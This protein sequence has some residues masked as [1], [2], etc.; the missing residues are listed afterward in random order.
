MTR[1]LWII[2]GA[3]LCAVLF[4]TACGASRKPA[5]IV[6]SKNDTEQILIGEIVAQHLE[7]RLGGKVARRLDL[8]GTAIVY[9]AFLNGQ[10]SVYPEYT[11]TIETMILK[12][13]PS[14]VP[15]TVFERTRSEMRRVAQAELL[16]PLGFENP[17]VLVIRASGSAGLRSLNSAAA[18]AGKWKLGV[19][20]DF[21]E[22]PD[23]LPALTGYHLPMSAPVRSMD[24]KLL[25]PAIDKGEVNMIATTSTD[26]HLLSEEWAV[27]EDDRKVFPPQ[28]ACLLVRQDKLAEEPRLRA[29]LEELSGKFTSE[30]MRRMN[31]RVEVDGQPL[32]SV[33]AAFLESAGLR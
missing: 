4:G 5:V 13:Q 21:Q 18:G 33:A 10:V 15:A 6:G 3:G 9:Q 17:P 31:A 32:A 29:A 27:L 25:F 22:R 19:T 20:L 28:Q 1:N 16:E 30:G 14:P 12:E 8:G 23:G 26:G 7:Q 11:G 24:P 2:L